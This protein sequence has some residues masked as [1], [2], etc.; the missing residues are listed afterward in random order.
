MLPKN[1]ALTND[2]YDIYVLLRFGI[3][4]PTRVDI[5]IKHNQFKPVKTSVYLKDFISINNLIP[6]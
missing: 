3:K 6:E 5:A 1:Y 4:Y 2:I